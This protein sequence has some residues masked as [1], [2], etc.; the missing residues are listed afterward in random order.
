MGGEDKALVL[1]GDRPL[2]QHVI[3]RVLPQTGGLVLSVDSPRAGL[4]RFGLAQ[5]GDP[6]AGSHGPLGGLL[7][8]MEAMPPPADWLLLVPCD[9][10]FVP[11]NLAE[12]LRQQAQ[13][14]ALPG[15]LVRYQGELQPTFSLWQRSL[16]ASLRSAVLQDGLGGFKQYLGRIRLSL[17]DWEEE[18]GQ[19]F[20]NVNRP[21]DLRRA[22]ALLAADG[23]PIS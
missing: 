6:R 21:E 4:D 13:R 11:W 10:P 7:A 18:P 23:G 5:V 17:L 2:L 9:A 8:A 1:L 19:P 14:S 12:R 16:L 20:L 3:D 22:E 15:C